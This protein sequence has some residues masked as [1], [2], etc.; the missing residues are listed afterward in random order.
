MGSNVSSSVTMKRQLLASFLLLVSAPFGSKSHQNTYVPLIKGLAERG[1]HVAL[2]T[3]YAVKGLQSLTNVEQIELESLKIDP[4]MFG[5]PFKKAL[6]DGGSTFDHIKQ[7]T[8]MLTSLEEKAKR[9]ADAVYTNPQVL[10]LI[11]SGKFDLVL[12]SQFFSSA[13]YP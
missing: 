6:G 11:E 5:D 8:N 1:H 4:S 3:N 7:M 12:G 10:Q 13:S 9:V 2:I